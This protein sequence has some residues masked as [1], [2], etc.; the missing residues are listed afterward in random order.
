[1]N[2]LLKTP[3][4][5]QKARRIMYRRKLRSIDPDM[6]LSLKKFAYDKEKMVENAFTT[7]R[8][9][10]I[11]R[12]CPPELEHLTVDELKERLIKLG[13]TM[14]KERL[15]SYAD[16]KDLSHSSDSSE[17]ETPTDDSESELEVVSDSELVE[18]LFA[19]KE[20]QAQ[21]KENEIRER[22]TRKRLMAKMAAKAAAAKGLEEGEIEDEVE[23]ETNG[24]AEIPLP[25]APPP[26]PIAPPTIG[27]SSIRLEYATEAS[28]DPAYTDNGTLFVVS[29][30]PAPPPPPPEGAIPVSPASEAPESPKPLKN[31]IVPVVDICTAPIDV[32]EELDYD[33]L[34][35]DPD[36]DLF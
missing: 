33:D 4:K 35:D 27:E 32:D 15:R 8:R 7:L 36:I 22:L 10:A 1:M 31:G 2:E 20:Q 9:G 16:D 12:I 21:A 11:E 6:F 13:S 19:D 24:L 23:M 17:V 30:I 28:P 5:H 18:A 26:P 14:S 25:P 3:P 34:G 29:D